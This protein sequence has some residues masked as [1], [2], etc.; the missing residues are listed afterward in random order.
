MKVDISGFN[1]RQVPL[2]EGLQESD[3]HR[4]ISTG[5]CFEYEAGTQLVSNS[6]PGETFF[7]I[8]QGL[9]K[10]SLINSHQEVVNVTLFVPGDFFGEMAMLVPA[11]ERSGDILAVTNLE[12][13][14]IHK[15]EFL[16]MAQ[17]CGMLSFNLAR[18]MAQRLRMMNERLVADALPDPLR[19]VAQTLVVLSSKGKPLAD[20]GQIL[21]PPLSL[22]DWSL[23]CYTTPEVFRASLDMLRRV[24]VV[25]LHKH[26][27][28]ITDLSGLANLTKVD[29]E[30]EEKDAL[31]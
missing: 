30:S 4:F 20:T 9:A 16:K 2:F 31:L 17:E 28:V 12:V 7:L 1:W 10:L 14:T 25:D 29:S 6:D 11:A 5:F 26:Q 24:G 23:F 21:L 19:K 15:K 8:L 18:N 22:H 27:V 3:V 13:M